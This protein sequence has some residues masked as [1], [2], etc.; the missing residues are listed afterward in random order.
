MKSLAN[1]KTLALTISLISVLIFGRLTSEAQ[2]VSKGNP[3]PQSSREY[4]LSEAEIQKLEHEALQG[5]TE[6]ALRLHF[7][8]E[9]EH[10][11]PAK[12]FFWAHISAQNADPMGQFEFGVMLSKDPDPKN[13]QRARFWLKKAAD[14]GNALAGH[15]L[16]GLPD[17]N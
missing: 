12:S 7:F 14:N 6:A 10:L 9:Y 8:Y 5:A 1:S 2:E 11:D 15:F 17:K 13:R 16:K 3:G 4:I